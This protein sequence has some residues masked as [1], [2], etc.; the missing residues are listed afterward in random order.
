MVNFMLAKKNELCHNLAAFRLLISVF[1][2]VIAS[3]NHGQNSLCL[4]S[5]KLNITIT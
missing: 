5:L 2:P 3:E 4:E 1:V